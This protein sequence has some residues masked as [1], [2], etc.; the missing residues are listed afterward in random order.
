ML[1]AKKGLQRQPKGRVRV[2]KEADAK[3]DRVERQ[4][5]P[6]TEGGRLMDQK[7]FFRS[8][9]TKKSERKSRE[10]RSE[11][12]EGRDRGGGFGHRRL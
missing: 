5:A 8:S 7:Q 2:A 4:N 1:C 6:V 9:F 11:A 10:G 3:G 12:R